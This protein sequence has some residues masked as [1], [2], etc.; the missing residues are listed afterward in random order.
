[1][2][3]PTIAFKFTLDLINLI[4]WFYFLVFNH[5]TNNLKHFDWMAGTISYFIMVVDL[6]M[7]ISNSFRFLY[8]HRS[9]YFSKLSSPIIWESPVTV[10]CLRQ[11]KA[12]ERTEEVAPGV[13][14]PCC[15]ATG[16][17]FGFQH[18]LW[19]VSS[20]DDFSTITAC[21]SSSAHLRSSSDLYWNL[22]S[23]SQTHR[24]TNN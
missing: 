18:H 20:L 15:S 4:C 5:F 14:S 2:Y 8:F 23:C 17:R 3:S 12:A 7:S 9:M 1:M 16:F 13:K 24:W 10:K 11:K 22:N 19:M 6:H 21:Y